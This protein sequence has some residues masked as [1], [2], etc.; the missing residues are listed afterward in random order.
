MRERLPGSWEVL[1]PPAWVPQEDLVRIVVWTLPPEPERSE[2]AQSIEETLG[3][4]VEVV[5]GD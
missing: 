5:Q 2:V 1:R 4:R 3:C